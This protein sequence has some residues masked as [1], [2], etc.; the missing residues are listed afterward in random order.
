[1]NYER[2]AGYYDRYVRW[3]TDTPFFLNETAKSSGQV[4]ELM[5]GTGRLSLPLIESGVKLTCVDSSAAMLRVLR[6]KLVKRGMSA[7]VIE[8]NVC[9]LD[10]G[11]QF[12]LI[13]LPFHSF[14]ELV[15]T[16]EQAAA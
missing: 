6:G 14:A 15:T 7:T 12:D 8:Q 1:M 10:P 2:V 13:I 4:L 11:K 5:S 3:D 16:S 9:A